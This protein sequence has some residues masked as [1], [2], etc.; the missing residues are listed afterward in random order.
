MTKTDIIK[1]AFKVW[2]RC[3]YQTTSLTDLARE[4]GVS[5]PALYRHFKDK[6]ALMEAMYTSYF[7][8]YAAFIKADHDRAMAMNNAEGHFI[9]M[10]R[11][12]EYY[13][14]N[15]DAFVFSLIR[16]F[17]SRQ[18]DTIREQLARRGVDNWR[19]VQFEKELSSYPSKVQLSVVTLTF[20][21]A[22][23]HR[24]EHKSDE[25]PSEAQVQQ[26][27]AAVEKRIVGG[28][29]LAGDRLTAIDYED[30]ER[31]SAET[32]YEDTQDNALLRAVA[33]AVAEAGP[34]NASM[35][36]VAQRSGL[37]KSGLYAHFKNKQD[38]MGQLFL[39][40]FDRIINYAELNIKASAVPEEQLYLAIISIADYLRSRPEIL[41]ALDW[42]RT[43]RLDLGLS[44]PP[45]LYR[46]ITNIKLDA[47]QERQDKAA[48]G[49]ISSGDNSGIC[50]GIDGEAET[51]SDWLAQWILFLIVHTL[52]RCPQP[53][54]RPFMPQGARQKGPEALQAHS[55]AEIPNDSFRIL[56]RFIAMGLKGF[57]I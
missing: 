43:R 3:L 9:L 53:G 1:A 20:W 35:E 48:G 54:E 30:L 46:F 42:I 16:V 4:L 11:I 49:G 56:F 40:E 21:I 24:Y 45:R 55:L 52:M 44:F 14:R 2:G 57:D 31:R 13:I 33:G 18:M 7:D 17:G 28:L 50:Y 10:R 26:A 51:S 19:M 23:F 38:M 36:M 34:W 29:G 22:H 8:D 27:L 39:T 32:V 47:F 5:K 15:R 12:T 6:E 41:V 25:I 37:S